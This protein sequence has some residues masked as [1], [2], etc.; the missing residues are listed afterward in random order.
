MAERH[1]EYIGP[2]L[3]DAY[4]P[5]PVGRAVRAV[6]NAGGDALHGGI[7]ENTPIRT[8]NLRTSWYR[9]PAIP[10]PDN[11]YASYVQTEVSYA[12][13]VEYG[14]G[15]YG[16]KH[17]KYL[18]GPHPPKTLLVWTDPKTGKK[19]AARRVMHPGSPGADMR[20]WGVAIAEVRLDQATLAAREVFKREIEAQIASAQAKVVKG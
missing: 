14:T 16:P 20:K 8:G 19:M 10:E 1:Y 15:L 17:A 6:C 2:N 7:T 5:A 12:P 11:R 9:V 3:A 4:D 18:I 13:Y